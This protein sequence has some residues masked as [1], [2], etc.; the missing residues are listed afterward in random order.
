MVV[1]TAVRPDNPEL[2]AAR[3]RGIPVVR[4]AEALA[5]LM[6]GRRAVCVAGT[7]G[8]TST[9]SMLTV[10]L[11]QAGVDPSFAIGGELRGIRVSARTMDRATSSSP[12]PTSRTAR[13]CRSPRT[14]RS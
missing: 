10:A 14:A 3:E 9:T 7:H 11:Q 1:S 12:R 2:R 5:A 13:S 4:R 8:K 6:S